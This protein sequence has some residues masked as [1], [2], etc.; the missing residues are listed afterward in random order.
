MEAVFMSF[1]FKMKCTKDLYETAYDI[2][3][4]V[5]NHLHFVIHLRFGNLLFLILNYSLFSD[6]EN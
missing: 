2:L 3:D 5:E 1:S 6:E 4:A